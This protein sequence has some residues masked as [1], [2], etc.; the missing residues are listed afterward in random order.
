ML[1]GEFDSVLLE[2]YDTRKALEETRRE[3]STALYQND[4][5]VRVIARVCGERDELRGRLEGMMSGSSTAKSGGGGAEKRSREDESE[6]EPVKKAKTDK[7]ADNSIPA[8]DMEAMTET[9]NKLSVVRRPIA[10]LKRAPEE[11]SAIESNFAKLTEKK[12]NVHKSNSN[13][14]LGLN[15]V[16]WK[17][18]DFVVSIGKDGQI[19][20]YNVTKGV[21]GHTVSCAGV[22]Y[23]HAMACDDI[24]Y[25]CACTSNE[26]KL[27]SVQ[28]ESTLLS[29]MDI[30]NAMGV[31]IHPSSSKDAVRIM[32]VSPSN[33]MLVKYSQGAAEMEV[34]VKLEDSSSN[35]NITA[36]EMHPDGLIYAMG[37]ESGKLIVWDL[38]TLAVASTLDVSFRV[39]G[40][41]FTD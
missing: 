10:K 9:W 6:A 14:V 41:S 32:I 22:S 13:G 8:S 4:A 15:A 19:L 5:A 27:F 25:L 23:I 38:K 7:D 37:T 39:E 2:L 20:V 40:W 1:Q 11:V 34:L 28:E 36:G 33:A 12:V 29:S 21:I 18:E 31:A 30:D 24:L 17:D 26:I 3:L 16:H 35:S